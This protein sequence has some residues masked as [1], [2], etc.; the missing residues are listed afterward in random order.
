MAHGSASLQVFV[1]LFRTH[2]ITLSVLCS[3]LRNVG[4]RVACT[5]ASWTC[6]VAVCSALRLLPHCVF[7]NRVLFTAETT[8]TSAETTGT[9]LLFPHTSSLGLRPRPHT[10][11]PEPFWLRQRVR[12]KSRCL[13]R[14]W[15]AAGA[16]KLFTPATVRGLALRNRVVV[17]PM[18]VVLSQLPDSQIS[19]PRCQ[20]SSIDGFMS[21]WHLRH[22]GS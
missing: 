11:P 20:Y 18:S 10:R 19:D 15:G 16:S 3:K 6:A 12:R 13:S 21:D 2:S 22:L 9:C 4:V 14:D 7:H 17:S 5:V 1:H 8:R